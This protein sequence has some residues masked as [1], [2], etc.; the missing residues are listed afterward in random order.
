MMKM[1][2]EERTNKHIDTVIKNIENVK[3][4]RKLW[5]LSKIYIIS[6]QLTKI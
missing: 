5:K 3:I 1:R 6:R 4:L 2:V